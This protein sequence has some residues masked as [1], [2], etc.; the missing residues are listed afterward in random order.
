M[1][2]YGFW[3][4]NGFMQRKIFKTG[5]SLAVT[6][7][8]KLQEELG[9]AE[10]DEVEIVAENGKAVIRKSQKNTQL[11]MPFSSRPKLGSRIPKE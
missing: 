3:G 11:A 1:S 7:S 10:G 8:K 4:H 6:I 9:V 5:H 2:T